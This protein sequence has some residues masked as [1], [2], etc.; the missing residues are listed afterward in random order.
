MNDRNPSDEILE[1]RKKARK[2]SA[3]LKALHPLFDASIDIEEVDA[4]LFE[5]NVELSRNEKLFVYHV[6][7][8]LL[9]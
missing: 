7:L 9:K 6:N 4:A 3:M 5:A 2:Q 1:K 8:N